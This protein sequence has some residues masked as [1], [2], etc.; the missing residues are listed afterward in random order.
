MLT[1]R[2][3]VHRIHPHHSSRG[4]DLETHIVGD[5][6]RRFFTHRRRAASAAAAASVR[7]AG[8]ANDVR[9][10]AENLLCSESNAL[11]EKLSD[12]YS[13]KREDYRRRELSV[14]DEIRAIPPALWTRTV[15]E[16]SS[17]W[18]N[19]RHAATCRVSLESGGP[20]VAWPISNEKV[21]DM[22]SLSAHDQS[23]ACT[24]LFNIEH[25]VT[26]RDPTKAGGLI[27]IFG[28]ASLL[29]VSASW[30]GCM[31][32]VGLCRSQ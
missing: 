4:I 17:K 23:F 2:S 22:S 1:Q 28:I 15:S 32:R 30:Q 13:A 11:V 27:S 21:P 24:V 18:R 12:R 25:R 20:G 19:D 9:C 8:K 29:E 3:F 16:M 26:R 10:I 6:A 7:E 14:E 5:R 31:N